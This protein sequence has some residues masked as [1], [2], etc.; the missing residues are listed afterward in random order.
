[1]EI[2]FASLIAHARNFDEGIKKLTEIW[3]YPHNVLGGYGANADQAEAD[4]K[5]LKADV[6]ALKVSKINFSWF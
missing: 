5:I 4:L 2:C 1:M 6:A 3:R